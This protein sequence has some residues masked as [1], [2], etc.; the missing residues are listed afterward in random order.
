MIHKDQKFLRGPGGPGRRRLTELVSPAMKRAGKEEEEESGGGGDR[1]A[2]DKEVHTGVDLMKMNG[3][4]H[5][6]KQEISIPDS[7]SSASVVSSM[8][9]LSNLEEEMRSSLIDRCFR[10]AKQGDLSGFKATSLTLILCNGGRS[11]INSM[12]D[13]RGRTLLHWAA[14]EGH[15]NF[16]KF[17]LMD[18]L[19]NVHEKDFDGKTAADL[20]REQYWKQVLKFILSFADAQLRHVALLQS[21]C[22]RHLQRTEFLRWHRAACCVKAR[23]AALPWRRRKFD[24]LKFTRMWFL[25]GQQGRS[26]LISP[27]QARQRRLLLYRNA[28]CLHESGCKYPLFLSVKLAALVLS[29]CVKRRLKS[30]LYRSAMVWCRKTGQPIGCVLNRLIG[31]YQSSSKQVISPLIRN[32]SYI[33]HSSKFHQQ[34]EQGGSSREAQLQVKK[35]FFEKKAREEE[36]RRR[37]SVCVQKWFRGLREKWRRE[38]RMG[39]KEEERLLEERFFKGKLFKLFSNAERSL[40]V[41]VDW[42]EEEAREGLMGLIF[43]HMKATEVMQDEEAARRHQRLLA[44][45]EFEELVERRRREEWRKKEE[46]AASKIQRVWRGWRR[47]RL[48]HEELVR[49]SNTG[50]ILRKKQEEEEGKKE[51]AR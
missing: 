44:Q 45:L 7:D 19:A 16:V 29:S 51:L 46:G 21:S 17:L 23:V 14:H 9:N 28:A 13:G 11:E 50:W 30:I 32:R 2:D 15:L 42:E 5:E 40:L 33:L 39:R 43:L 37:S 12:Q 18:M 34:L 26:L 6:R 38:D 31:R 8:S 10:Q 49:L 3:Q 4:A 36:R 27:L 25:E 20:A 47:R 48:K 35:E 24:T 41:Y 1:R 22:R